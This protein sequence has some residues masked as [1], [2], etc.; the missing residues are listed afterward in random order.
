MAQ[1]VEVKNAAGTVVP[2]KPLDIAAGDTK[3]DFEFV[4][5]VKAEDLK[6]VWTVAGKSY[7]LDLFN[8][9]AAFLNAADQIA[10]NKA[11][12]DLGVANVKV[13]NLPEYF[14]AKGDITKSAD[15]LTVAD[16]QKLVDDVNAKSVDSETAKA[17]VKA[18]TD[19][20]AANNQVALLQALQNKVFVRVNPNW[21]ATVTD[22]YM[23]KIATTDD[24]IAKIQDKINASNDAILVATVTT[25]GVDKA[26]LNES[27]DLIAKYATVDDKGV[28]T[29]V[30]LKGYVDTKVIDIQLAIAD[31]VQ[32]TTPTALKTK[33][34]ALA[35]LVN[36]KTGTPV[37]DMTKYVDVNG[38]AYI[39]EIAKVAPA[40][41]TA[42]D[43]NT[44]I[45]TV[46]GAAN[47]A[48]VD[49]V[50]AAASAPTVDADKLLKA[51]NDLG[52]KQVAA[53]NKDAYAA[54]AAFKTVA[55]KDAAQSA[56]D[57]VNLAAITGAT[58]ADKLLVALKVLELKNVVDANK[59]AYLADVKS[60]SATIKTD[61]ATI[62]NA[63][64]A[65]NINV[66]VDAQVKAINGAKTV[67]EVKTALDAL[68]NVDKVSDYLKIRSVD[69]DFVAASV[70][71]QRPDGGF[72]G[73]STIEEKV[74]ASQ[75]DYAAA[76]DGINALKLTDTPDT[77]VTALNAMLDESF[78][79]LSNTEKSLKAQAF[80]DK[81][82]FK[83][84]GTLKTPFV[85]LAA[86]K[87]L[88]K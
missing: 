86:V 41:I 42:A 57:A 31:V 5:A 25:T 16:V 26:K 53:S 85:T 70:L 83:E 46:N 72:D 78:G 3:A 8:K 20:K 18:V 51:L 87:D 6:G 13:E 76:L 61:A 35:T 75:T 59:D 43:I 23:A 40:T 48:L 58:D 19:A 11:L 55:D 33:L 12:T 69:R 4:T 15:Q 37:L 56:V 79:A 63:L 74:T 62:D 29:D 52:L 82:T 27:K 81:L 77:V 64:K 54:A 24:T 36:P 30:T 22:G 84:D 21:V 68:A 47:Q 9:L 28:I 80:Q 14:T 71:K 66:V 67:S 50:K 73:L 32:A 45:T 34:T 60:G 2:V 10:L 49:A 38:K 1:T 65:I 44:A 39:A 7:D 17:I 88:L